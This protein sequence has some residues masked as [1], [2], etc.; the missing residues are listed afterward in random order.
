[1]NLALARRTGSCG[2]NAVEPVGVIK[3]FMNSTRTR[4]SKSLVDSEEGSSRLSLRGLP[5]AIAG[6]S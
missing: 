5:Y 6:T 1:M 3:S 2:S 4:D